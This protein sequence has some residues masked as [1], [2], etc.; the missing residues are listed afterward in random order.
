[1]RVRTTG[2]LSTVVLK[3]AISP[4]S[5]YKA[6]N[7]RVNA[8][9][10]ATYS[11]FG[12]SVN[13]ADLCE[14]RN[15]SWSFLSG[16]LPTCINRIR[17]VQASINDQYFGSLDFGHV[18][19]EFVV[20]DTSKVIHDVVTKGF[21]ALRRKG[22][23]IN[24][25]YMS[26][27]IDGTAAYNP[28]SGPS[29][30]EPNS[31]TQTNATFPGKGRT[32]L[33]VQHQFSGDL[34]ATTE[35]ATGVTPKV[36]QQILEAIG[37]NDSLP[38]YQTAVNNAFAN[39][40][41]ADIE[42]LT[43]AAEA[44]STLM[45][46]VSLGQRIASIQKAIKTGKFYKI[47][48]KTWKRYLADKRVGPVSISN[49]FLDAWME[50]RYAWRPL[51]Y[52]ANGVIKYLNGGKDLDIRKTFRGGSNDEGSRSGSLDLEDSGFHYKVEFDSHYTHKVRAGVI[53][54]ASMN[55]NS[56]HKL[57]LFNVAVTAWD[58]VPYS[59]VAG[60]FVDVSGALH[61]LN[62][63]PIY[64]SLASWA[65]RRASDIVLLKITVT[66]PNGETKV[67]NSSVLLTRRDRVPEVGRTFLT[68]DLNFD[69]NKLI[70]S[71]AMLRRWM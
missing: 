65:S 25:P 63:N 71:V 19:A 41:S 39:Q 2:D 43:A 3:Q 44:N 70:D 57:G 58:L 29:K 47:A 54:H 30:W 49:Y 33:S 27:V 14:F 26:N 17:A 7:V 11:A 68:F 10:S 20:R 37:G 69:Q 16:S 8:S 24:N 4:A 60:W 22:V 12:Q 38:D 35:F 67:L 28:G 36:W 15:G 21:A 34:A 56:A 53:G 31:G 55:L 18:N 13:L 42:L 48:P 50:V 64:E 62:P 32:Q 61:T 9:P 40:D 6:V 51:I 59:F 1:M 5:H 45:S 23:I 66:P 46:F 52:D